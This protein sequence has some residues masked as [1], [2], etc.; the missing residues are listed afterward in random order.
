MSLRAVTAQARVELILTLR[1]GGM[2]GR[3]RPR[4][5][6]PLLQPARLPGEFF[7]QLRHRSK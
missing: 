2:H 5:R 7:G 4:N 3:N 6:R 1:R